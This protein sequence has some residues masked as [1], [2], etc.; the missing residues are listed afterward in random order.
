MKCYYCGDK[1]SIHVCNTHARSMLSAAELRKTCTGA[2]ETKFRNENDEPV[3]DMKDIRESFTYTIINHPQIKQETKDAFFRFKN[4]T[5]VYYRKK[6][7]REKRKV[8]IEEF[9][10]SAV[11]KLDMSYFPEYKKNINELIEKLVDEKLTTPAECA[12]KIYKA[13]EEHIRLHNA[14]KFRTELGLNFLNTQTEHVRKIFITGRSY[15]R[16]IDGYL[17]YE[18]FTN[19]VMTYIET[20]K[21]REL[22]DEAINKYIPENYRM[23]CRD[24]MMADN[25]IKSGNT[26]SAEGLIT[27]FEFMIK[28]CEAKKLK[29]LRRVDKFFNSF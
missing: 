7:I 5:E 20:I 25:Y 18:D 19:E 26:E 6:M 27:F 12:L 24:T 14:K 8:A 29:G 4:M 22:L 28:K 10:Y 23:L 21:R 17:Q 2:C 9:T 13:F 15:Q 11:K 3:Y 16:L 1:E